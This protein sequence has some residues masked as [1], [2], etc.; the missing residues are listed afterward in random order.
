[1]VLMLMME[2]PGAM[3]S[4][5]MAISRNGPFT[6]TPKVLSNSSSVTPANEGGT[7]AIPALLTSTSMRPN[8]LTV[9]STS[10]SHCAQSAT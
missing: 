5:A 6:L 2:P 4:A 7:G 1:L 3:C 8:S 10:A 9:A